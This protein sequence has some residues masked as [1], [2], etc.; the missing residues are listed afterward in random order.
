[1]KKLCIGEYIKMIDLFICSIGQTGN[2]LVGNLN[3][4]NIVN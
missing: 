2:H 3:N 4:V 1:M